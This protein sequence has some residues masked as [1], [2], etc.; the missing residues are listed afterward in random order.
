[1][2]KST[3]TDALLKTIEEF[4]LFKEMGHALA[5]ATKGSV[6]FSKEANV[7][8]L[9][10]IIHNA[11]KATKAKSLKDLS[12]VLA[13]FVDESFKQKLKENGRE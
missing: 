3:Q 7:M 2:S 1:M 11:L 10:K 5:K 13:K 6:N 8:E 12:L 9:E 4:D